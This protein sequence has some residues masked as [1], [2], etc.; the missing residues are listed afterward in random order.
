MKKKNAINAAEINEQIRLKKEIFRQ[1]QKD[2]PFDQKMK[3]AFSLA[4]R[5]ETIRQAVL[6]TKTKKVENSGQ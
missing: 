4:E 6:L 1:H 5:D 3:I 2:L